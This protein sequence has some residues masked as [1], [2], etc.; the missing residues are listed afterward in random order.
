MAAPPAA[1]RDD[2]RPHNEKWTSD[3]SD[4]SDEEESESATGKRKWEPFNDWQKLRF[5]WYYETYL[6]TIETHAPKH[7]EG[8]K[9]EV[10]PFEGGTTVFSATDSAPSHAC[11][12][13]RVN[14]A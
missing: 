8:E 6:T 1:A 2:E 5:L 4:D 9:F 12:S 13:S 3:D 10:M 7:K 11:C 14:D